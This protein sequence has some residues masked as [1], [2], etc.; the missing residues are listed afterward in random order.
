MGKEHGIHRMAGARPQVSHAR[1][2]NS[3]LITLQE[4]EQIKQVVF[5]LVGLL[6]GLEGDNGPVGNGHEE[7]SPF[8]WKA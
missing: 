4:S 6:H 8:G 2:I 3:L 7:P 1:S 5:P